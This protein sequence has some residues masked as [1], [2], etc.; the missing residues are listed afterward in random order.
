VI[1]RP[2]QESALLARVGVVYGHHD[3]IALHD[4]TCTDKSSRAFEVSFHLSLIRLK[5][6]RTDEISAF[7]FGPD[8]FD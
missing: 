3:L 5:I 7:D 6:L 4:K 2:A 1:A 8:P